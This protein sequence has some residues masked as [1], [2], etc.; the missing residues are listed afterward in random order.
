MCE[1]CAQS[2]AAAAAVA[3]RAEKV[4]RLEQMLAEGKLQQN[5]VVAE[6]RAAR[7]AKDERWAVI[8]SVIAGVAFL[9]MG[10]QLYF[11]M[12]PPSVLSVEEVRALELAESRLNECVQVFWRVADL[13]QRDQIPDPSLACQEA[14]APLIVTRTGDDV[15][16]THPR[17]ELLGYA[18]IS[19]TKS[20]PIPM[21][22][23]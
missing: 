13:L 12:G 8:Q 6:A 23:N 19:V 11:S 10:V 17:P 2:T 20:N 22:L 3:A 21:L 18:S 14:G 1:Q 16:V 9:A 7:K 5:N 4:D 15:I